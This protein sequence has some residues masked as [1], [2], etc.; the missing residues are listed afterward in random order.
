MCKHFLDIGLQE[1]SHSSIDSSLQATTQLQA[2]YA[3]QQLTGSHMLPFSTVTSTEAWS[4]TQE[5]SLQTT[6]AQILQNTLHAKCLH[7]LPNREHTGWPVCL[8]HR[9]KLTVIAFRFICVNP[10][11][12]KS[13][14]P[15]CTAAPDETAG[16]ALPHTGSQAAQFHHRAGLF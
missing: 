14:V 2:I 6:C 3:A 4:I 13:A 12:L 11:S 5:A 10:N 8:E 16:E 9:P 7:L 1:H 15:S